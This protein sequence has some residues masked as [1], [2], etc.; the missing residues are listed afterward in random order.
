MFKRGAKLS[1]W[2]HFLAPGPTRKLRDEATSSLRQARLLL[3]ETS[4]SH[5]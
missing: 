4:S 2:G 3:E 5:G 1:L